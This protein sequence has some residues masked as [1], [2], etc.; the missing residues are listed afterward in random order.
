DRDYKHD[1]F[2]NQVVQGDEELRRAAALGNPIAKRMLNA[3]ENA[4]EQETEPG[5]VI[6]EAADQLALEE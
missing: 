5:P 4:V 3:H 2:S 6:T 1:R